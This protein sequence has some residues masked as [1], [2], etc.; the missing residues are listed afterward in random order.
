MAIIYSYIYIIGIL[1]FFSISIFQSRDRVFALRVSFITLF[2]Y[3]IYTLLA[4]LGYKNVNDFFL[5][6]DQYG[7]YKISCEL[8]DYS[9]IK[10][11]FISCFVDRIHIENEGAY[12]LMGLIGYV[13]N[14]YFDGNSVLLQMLHVSFAASLIPLMIFKL[15]RYYFPSKES[16]YYALCYLFCSYIFAYSAW[17][18]RD[19][20]I[21]LFSILLLIL[22]HER[23]SLWILFLQFFIVVV[24]LE[25][26]FESG[27]I[28]F[29]LI[30]LYVFIKRKDVF[31]YNKIL[32]NLVRITAIVICISGLTFI[33][34]KLMDVM[35]YMDNYVQYT[36]NSLDQDNSGLGRIVYQFP[37]GIKHVCIVLYSQISSFPCW[38]TLV[39]ARNV[40]EIFV[41]IVYMISPIFWFFINYM[42][43]RVLFSCDIHIPLMVKYLCVF[44]I[45]FLF[46]NT[47]NMNIR[48]IFCFYP[49]PFILYIQCVQQISLY[50]RRKFQYEAGRVYVVLCMCYI[51]MKSLI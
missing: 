7:F 14:M 48:R 3:G 44:Y 18:L 46:L 21:A 9:S 8:G 28:S 36:E 16:F 26:R 37:W 15:L 20:H 38:S 41:G 33:V 25:F 17:L 10:Q 32:L 11:L 6:S 1:L 40:Y 24:L 39:Q 29:P 13:A 31:G 12:F 34:S 50:K 47:S 4:Y 22:V 49:I 5:Y 2:V 42:I 51:L 23:F 27:L 30:L 35:F 19:I 43:I 45:A